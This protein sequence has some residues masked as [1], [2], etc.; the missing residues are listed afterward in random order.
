MR[1]EF[2]SYPKSSRAIPAPRRPTYIP[3]SC[4]MFNELDIRTGESSNLRVDFRAGTEWSNLDVTTLTTHQ[5][6]LWAT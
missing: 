5:G 6:R 2:M 4:S 1:T 3:V